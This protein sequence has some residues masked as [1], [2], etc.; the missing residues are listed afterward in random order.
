LT[1]ELISSAGACAVLKD[2]STGNVA[3][4]TTNLPLYPFFSAVAKVWDKDFNFVKVVELPGS[5]EPGNNIEILHDIIN[6]IPI[7]INQD[8]NTDLILT[9]NGNFRLG[10]ANG[11]MAVLINKGNFVFENA[12][13]TYLPNQ[14]KKSFFNYYHTKL[15]VDGHSSIYLDHSGK[16]S[17]W[18]I[19]NKSL[20]KYKEDVL[21]SLVDGFQYTNI[22]KTKKGF[23]LF[24]VKT[25]DY[26]Y[27]TFYSR[28]FIAKQ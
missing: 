3:V 18:Q 7:D 13:D 25:I 24:L 20:I 2:Q 21:N 6:V 17:L 14:D 10:Y 16:A 15:S 19:K 1:Q 11:T 22:Y 23:S 5:E 12:T 4:V 26:P 28:P 9:D 8:G 27:A